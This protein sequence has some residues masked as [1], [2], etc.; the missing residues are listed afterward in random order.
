MERGKLT[1]ELVGLGIPRTNLASVGVGAGVGHAQG[2]RTVVSQLRTELVLKL[3]SPDGFST[4]PGAERVSGL[5]HELTDNSVEDVTI[6]I[7]I[8]SMNTEVLHSLRTL[9]WEQIKVNVSHCC[10]DGGILIQS[11]WTFLLRG[12]NDVL[13]A[14]L[15]IEHISLVFH[16]AGVFTG[17]VGEEVEPVFLVSRAKEDGLSAGFG[18]AGVVRHMLLDGGRNV[19]GP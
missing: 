1:F 17:P 3:A 9:P 13:L 14:R 5:Y 19:A 18:Q 8:A 7:T 15:L 11:W 2:V 6:V 4:S 10:V 12:S 16:G